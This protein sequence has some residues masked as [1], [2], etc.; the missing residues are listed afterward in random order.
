MFPALPQFAGFAL[1]CVKLC[2]VAA[3]ASVLVAPQPCVQVKVLTPACVH[4]G[5]RVTVPV[6]LKSWPS[7]GIATVVV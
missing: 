2:P 1:Y 3:I 7:A 5:C 4:V 6:P